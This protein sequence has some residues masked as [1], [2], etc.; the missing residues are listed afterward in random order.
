[1]REGEGEGV[2]GMSV[3]SCGADMVEKR[4][5]ERVELEVW[6]RRTDKRS[7]LASLASQQGS[8]TPERRHTDHTS[9]THAL[10]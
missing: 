1:V 4:E 9:S 2:E 7:F 6:Q 10:E 3:A 5:C 8:S